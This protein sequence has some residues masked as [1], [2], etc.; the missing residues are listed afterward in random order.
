MKRWCDIGTAKTV[1]PYLASLLCNGCVKQLG[2]V[3]TV[4]FC[5]LLGSKKMCQGVED[6]SLISGS[7]RE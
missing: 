4:R 1:R 2:R 6:A 7:G 3:E 5:W